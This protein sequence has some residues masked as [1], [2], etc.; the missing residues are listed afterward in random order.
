MLAVLISVAILST[1]M[2]A[3]VRSYALRHAVL[4]IPNERSS[5]VVPTPRGG[6]LGIVLAT[7]AGLTIGALAGWLEFP[8][9]LAVVVGGT[10]VAAIGLLDDHRSVPA[11][12]RLA[13]HVGAALWAVYLLGGL[14]DLRLGNAVLPLGPIGWVLSVF[15]IVWVTNLYN[16]MDGIDGIAAGEAFSVG[17]A[18]AVIGT[19]TGNV[20]IAFVAGVIA[21]GAGGF[22]VWN[23]APARIFMGDVG[24]CFLGFTLI[25]LALAS[26]RTGGPPL[27]V[28]LILLGVFVLDATTT[29]VRRLACGERWSAP[30]RHHAYQRAVQSGLSHG[31][32]SGYVLGI[33]AGL[34]LLALGA[35]L[36]PALTA[37]VTLSALAGLGVLYLIVERRHPMRPGSSSNTG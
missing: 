7:Q 17:A 2:T 31:T 6:G 11:I 35:V 34:G 32:V 24:S 30:H 12:V 13:V 3:G 28:W 4:D 15:G 23:W 36:N 19:I 33:N 21:A 1:L 22:L 9:F 8:V 37:L 29:L 20:G 5:H 26:E 27:L 16:F 18:A 25:V 14:S 10:L